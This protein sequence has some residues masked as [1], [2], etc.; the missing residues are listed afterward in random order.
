MYFILGEL[1]RAPMDI[2]KLRD[3][4]IELLL[5]VAVPVLIKQGRLLL[6]SMLAYCYYESAGCRL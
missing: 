1:N 4:T 6:E 2:A 3:V 5:L